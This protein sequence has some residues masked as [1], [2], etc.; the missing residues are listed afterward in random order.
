MLTLKVKKP[1]EDKW[2]ISAVF[3]QV[4]P[5][6]W[7]D[8]HHGTDFAT[9]VGT[10]VFCI[11]QGKVIDIFENHLTLGNAIVVLSKRL[12]CQFIHQYCHLS[13][14][15]A[16]LGDV[17]PVGILI[18]ATGASGHVSGPHLHF[19]LKVWPSGEHICPEFI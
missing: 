15:Y 3:G 11:E 5:K 16:D 4:N 2:P 9:P 12:N 13:E 6:L 14:V 8:Y 17:K 7:L 1:V 10:D 18:G 19:G